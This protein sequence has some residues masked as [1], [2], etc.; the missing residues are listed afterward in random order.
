MNLRTLIAPISTTVSSPLPVSWRTQPPTLSGERV[1]LRELVPGEAAALLP[2]LSS[3]EVARFISVPPASVER[4]AAF[5]EW[6]QRERAAGRYIGF[7][8]VPAGYDVPVGLLQVRQLDPGFH[9]AEWGFALGSG[10]WGAGFFVEAARLLIDFA[11]DTLGVHRLEARA[12]IDNARGQAAMRKLGAVQ[13][14]VL[15]RS[16]L[17]ADGRHHDQALWSLLADDWRA[18]AAAPVERVH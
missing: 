15:R 4:F 17:T 3:P 11:F 8:L 2:L 7:G 18:V 1:A 9:A 12:A 13:E 16:L 5:I 10:F 14:G 6:S